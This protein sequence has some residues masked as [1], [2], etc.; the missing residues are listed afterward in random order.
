MRAATAMIAGERICAHGRPFCRCPRRPPLMPTYRYRLL[1]FD[2]DGTLRDS[3]GSIVGC[4][5]E[6]LASVGI[7]A[8]AGTIRGSI[9]LGM[10]DA[11]LRWCP[12]SDARTRERVHQA[13]G[14]L[15]R[16]RWHR[17]ADLFPG[18]PELLCELA[19]AGYWL[20]I[21]TGKSRRGLDG[22]LEHGV[23]RG[24]ASR[25][26]GIRTADSSPP[27]PSPAMVLGLAEELGVRV[28]D[29]LVVGDSS[30]DL[31]MARAAG[32]DAVGVTSGA[33]P[34][35]A[36][37]ALGPRAVLPDVLHLAPWLAAQSV[38]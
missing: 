37:E 8:D 34:R 3:V 1:I 16:A 13:Y 26:L 21:A 12:D 32:C 25:F 30:H 33:L 17:E 36:L 15:W 28:G 7:A 6:A 35:P 23:A 10:A 18:V 38:S 11:V 19:S 14:D 31:E 29:C 2:W 5:S 9:G 27:K 22:D 20:A 24:L 4:A